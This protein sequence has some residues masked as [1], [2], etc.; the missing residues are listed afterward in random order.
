MDEGAARESL[1]ISG[2]CVLP[3]AVSEAQADACQ[4]VILRALGSLKEPPAGDQ[5]FASLSRDGTLTGLLANSPL[6]ALVC[7]VLGTQLHHCGDVQVALRFPGH[8]C[9]ADFGD[10]FLPALGW[11]NWWHIDGQDAER[12]GVLACF[13]A[14]VG[15]ALSDV[16]AL[17]AGALAVYPGGHRLLHDWLSEGT[18]L[19][20]LATAGN[21]GLPRSLPLAAAKQ[22]LLRKGDAVVLHYLMPHNVAPNASP[23]LRSMAYFRVHAIS[24]NVREWPPPDW[25]LRV[26]SLYGDWPAVAALETV[27]PPTMPCSEDEEAASLRA[28]AE[29]AHAR[30]DWA[31]SHA[32][33][34]RLHALRPE[35]LNAA[36]RGGCA[37]VHSAAGRPGEEAAAL[38]RAGEELLAGPCSQLEPLAWLQAVR[39]HALMLQGR[40]EEAEEAYTNNVLGARSDGLISPRVPPNTDWQTTLVDRALAL[41]LSRLDAPAAALRAAHAESFPPPPAAAE[42]EVLASLTTA[43]AL[44]EKGN[45]HLHKDDKSPADWHIAAAIFPRLALLQPHNFWAHVNAAIALAFP[46]GASTD[47]GWRAVRYA[48][49]ATRCDPCSYVGLALAVKASFV[50]RGARADSPLCVSETLVAFEALCQAPGPEK[51]TGDSWEHEWLLKAALHCVQVSTTAERKALLQGRLEARFPGLFLKPDV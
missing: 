10:A 46:P 40:W 5:A 14:L 2:Y 28:S 21:G 25:K 35:E 16:P 44:T 33:H 41:L 15:V 39:C 24:A 13:T 12:P 22:L 37:A 30:G 45:A 9:Q 38:G 47:D 32:L 31:Q 36:L 20:E 27:S 4:R 1:R 48:R 7:R 17:N 6:R 11:E 8:A 19:S 26:L 34:A 3:T 49:N 18:R 43:A 50:A 42:E 29:A 51:A 23:Q